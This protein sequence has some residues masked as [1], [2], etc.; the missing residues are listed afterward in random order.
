VR[1]A[2]IVRSV[3]P[4]LDGVGD[5]TSHLATTLRAMGVEACI[6]T[7]ADQ[8]DRA[9]LPDWIHP[10]VRRWTGAAVA[11]ALDAIPKLS[12]DWCSFQYVPQ[13]YGP[14]G[15]CWAAAGVPGALRRVLGCRSAVT[16]HEIA[17]SMRLNP[18]SIVLATAMRAQAR[19]L[20]SACD[21]VVTTCGRYARELDAMAPR[22]VPVLDIP[23]GTNIE[24]LPIGPAGLSALRERHGLD[25]A[26][27]FGVFG[28]PT[29]ERNYPTAVRALVR[30]RRQGRRAR[31]L[32]LGPWDTLR[33]GMER[34]VSAV[35]REHGV[36]DDIV[37][38]G[39]LSR[40]ELSAHL[41]L[42]DVFLFP[43]ADGVSTRNTSVMAALAHGLP[44]VTY[45]P[46]PGNFDG[47]G[48]PDGAV[49]PQGAED[50]FVAAAVAALAAPRTSRPG[51]NAVYFSEHFSWRRIAA[52]FLEA[53]TAAAARRPA[54]EPVG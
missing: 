2:F 39:P 15:F 24:P 8:A 11:G 44:V 13:L 17:V 54:R 5:Y 31:L 48:A 52:R 20:L 40:E 22:G 45:A 19:R 30:A 7:S 43:Q 6:V 46:A 41:R 42:M 18:K 34:E 35:A 26:S 14:H 36:G 33:G 25:G 28:R 4:T 21:L 23:V 10:V 29:G 3:P 12:A 51:P 32:V 37:V 49:V 38:T 27:V 53:L 1:I 50:A 9:P 16:F 47:Y